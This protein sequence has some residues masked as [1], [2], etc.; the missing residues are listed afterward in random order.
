MVG[1]CGDDLD[2][3]D[4][5]A[6]TDA[7][8]GTDGGKSTTG[9]QLQVEGPNTCFPIS[10]VSVAQQAVSHSTA[11]AEMLAF[12]YLLRRVALPALTFWQTLKP[13]PEAEPCADSTGDQP[14]RA[15]AQA[16][17]RSIVDDW[18][19]S[20]ADAAGCLAGDAPH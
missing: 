17:D 2:S 1:W 6:Y 13:E 4:L 16:R 7:N 19:C 11:E 20:Q 5:H 15:L 12:S 8:L 9:V 14:G 10:A 3:I 18:E